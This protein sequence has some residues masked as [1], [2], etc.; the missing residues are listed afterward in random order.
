MDKSGRVVCSSE[1]RRV[2]RQVADP[3]TDTDS[4]MDSAED[5]PAPHGCYSQ[6]PTDVRSPSSPRIPRMRARIFDARS[7]YNHACIYKC[8][9]FIYLKKFILNA[10]IIPLWKNAGKKYIR[11]LIRKV[12]IIIKTMYICECE[13]QLC[14]TLCMRF[15]S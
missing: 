10:N 15:K 2:P 7:S 14:T 4:L 13:T 12:T 9:I 5:I 8:R 6:L 1:H 3:P 11:H